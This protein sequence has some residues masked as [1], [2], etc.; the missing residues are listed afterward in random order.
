MDEPKDLLVERAD[1]VLTLTL[2]RPE[3][4]NAF[5]EPM[6]ARLLS[7]VTA[8]AADDDVRVIVLTGAGR[9]FCAGA[10][11][12]GLADAASG[13]LGA[14]GLRRQLRQAFVPVARALLDFEKPLVAAVNGPCAGAGI[15]MAL[16]CDVVV[17]SEAASFTFAFAARGLVPDYGVT[18]LLPR[19]VGLRAARELCLLGE[20]VDA[21]RADRLGLVTAVVPP[22]ELLDVA[23]EYA[24]RLAAGAGL[25]LG[26][27]KRLLR[28][29]FEVDALTAVD[30]EFTAQS[31][32]LASE[33]AA[34]GAAAFLEKRPPRF[35]GR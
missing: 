5:D 14:G 21:A 33:D 22:G 32:C 28:E 17:A 26:L 2:N 8:A 12:S 10:D 11:V 34:E 29:T 25:A 4:L 20:R 9:G 24:Q 35:A 1:S 19:L 23:G 31:L 13:G 30:R 27:T 7:T 18:H 6:A 15:G 3:R 16:A